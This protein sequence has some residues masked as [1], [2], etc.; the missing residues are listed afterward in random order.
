[1]SSVCRFLFRNV[2]LYTWD[3]DLF[4]ELH[5]QFA[6]SEQLFGWGMELLNFSIE[7]LRKK[8]ARYTF[9]V[10]C[11]ACYGRGARYTFSV[12]CDA[13]HGRGAALFFFLGL[14]QFGSLRPLPKTDSEKNKTART[15][16][17]DEKSHGLGTQ[18]ESYT[19]RKR[20][21]SDIFGLRSPVISETVFFRRKLLPLS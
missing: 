17:P 21:V 4:V 8:G 14:L 6:Q 13:C 10:A 20:P 19:K 16:V 1:M 11:D 3:T 15:Y 2:I 5:C 12:A 18:R 7:E 9:S